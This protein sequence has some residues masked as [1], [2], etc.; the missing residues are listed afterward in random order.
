MQRH[1]PPRPDDERT[2]G[3]VP[4][5]FFK[6]EGQMDN[7]GFIIPVADRVAK[8]PPYVFATIFRMKEQALADGRVVFDLGVG[9]PDGRPPANIVRALQDALGDQS[10]NCHRYCTFNGL[11]RFREAIARWYFDRFAVGLD[12]G[13]EV[14][15][16]I[17]SK[18]GLANLMR[19]YLNTGDTVILPS[20]CYPAYFGAARLCEAE[21]FE[22]AL[23]PQNGFVPDLDEVP[24]AVADR[25]RMIILNYPNN[26]TGGTCDLEFYGRAVDWCRR[27]RV[28]LVSDIAYSELAFDPDRQPPSVLQIGGAKE[29]AVEFQSLSKSHNLAGWRVGFAAGGAEVIGNLGKLKS[30]VDFSLFGAIQMAGAEA[31]TGSQQVCRDNRD[32]YRHRRNLMVKGFRELGWEVPKPP[33]TMYIW[34]AVPGAY[35]GDDFGFVKDVFAKTGV[36][37]SPGSGFG[38]HGAGFVRA[39]LVADDDQIAR[40][41]AAL[42]GADIAWG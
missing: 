31:L 2:D 15:P 10:W 41:M 14:L 28:M 25:A 26:P 1:G 40:I 11:A 13:S 29:V 12:P 23:R 8:L 4:I 21:I 37:F 18:E 39:S 16:L 6:H 38:T 7:P 5:H 42:R 22:L 3:A 27:H 19:T 36:L 32:L 20:P 35:R 9:N 30:N 17:G 24:P 34:A 33:A